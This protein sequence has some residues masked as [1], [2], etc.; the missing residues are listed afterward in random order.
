MS[1]IILERGKCIGCGTCSV[2]CPPFFESG[3]DGRVN[4]KESVQKEENFEKEVR[5]TGCANEAE[6]GCPVQCIHVEEN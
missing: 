3:K 2:I 4:L 6:Q 5:D 1:K